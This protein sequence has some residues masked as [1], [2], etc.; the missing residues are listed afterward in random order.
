MNNSISKKFTRTLIVLAVASALLTAC[1]SA[2]MKPAP[3]AEA[4]A[5]LNQLQSDPNL[6]NRAPVAM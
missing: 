1:A 3:A 4:R 6:A 2:P 5:K